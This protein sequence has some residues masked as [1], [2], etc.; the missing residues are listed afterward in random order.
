MPKKRATVTVFLINYAL[1]TLGFGLWQAIFN[2]FAV[3]DLGVRADQIGLIQSIREVPGLMG[4]MMGFL[5]L[6][7]A[8]SRIAGLAAIVMGLGIA[9]T[10][11]SNTPLILIATTLLMSIGFHFSYSSNAA[12]LLLTAGPEEGPQT[13][14]RMNSLG[15]LATVISTAFIFATLDALGYRTLFIVAGGLVIVGNLIIWPFVGQ[16][17]RGETERQPTR[18]RREYWL[19]YAL[20]FLNGSRRH[21]VSTFAVFLLVQEYNVIAQV[22]TLLFL[23]NSL[24]GTYLNHAFGAIVARYGEKRVLAANYIVL[25]IIFAA[26]AFIPQIQTLNATT[27][28]VPSLH[29]GQWVLL[30]AFEATIGLIILLCIFIVDRAM[31]GFSIA[32]ESYM[33]KIAL[34]PQDITGNIALGQTI[35]HI[36]AVVIPVTGGIMWETIG[37]RYT[38]LVGM[39]IVLAA[40][41][42]TTRLNTGKKGSSAS[43][44]LAGRG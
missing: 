41:A 32:V 16:A 13:L 42:L 20:Q 33:Q 39:G 4:F 43:A 3:E 7:L 15:A 2:N 14:G 19:Y 6:I 25:T 17:D 36:A 11:A 38:F 26:Y 9:L 1:M 24:V 27:F 18:I 23:L 34:S 12:A 22:I 29:I 44:P 28:D 21:I 40:L 10:A 8:E 37:A 5:A 30:P 31:M 35:N